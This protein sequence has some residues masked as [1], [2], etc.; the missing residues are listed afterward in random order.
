MKTFEDF[1]EE[2]FIDNGN[3]GEMPVTKDNVED[4]FDIY[5][6]NLDTEELLELGNEYGKSLIK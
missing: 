4:L 6:S 5:L 2:K 1:L 3:Y